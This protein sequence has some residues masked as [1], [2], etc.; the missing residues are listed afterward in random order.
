MNDFKI[1]DRV[2]FVR[3]PIPGGLLLRCG[4]VLEMYNT[5][6][7]VQIGRVKLAFEPSELALISRKMVIS[8]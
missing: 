8:C 3:S 6:L 7:I 4:A 1:S 5:T 2:Q